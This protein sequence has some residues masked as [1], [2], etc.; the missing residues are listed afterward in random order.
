[1]IASIAHIQSSSVIECHVLQRVELKDSRAVRLRT[2]HQTL[3]RTMT[4]SPSMDAII[5]LIADVH[6]LIRIDHHR[7]G[8]VQLAI[9]GAIDTCASNGYTR[10]RSVCPA[11]DAV[12]VWISDV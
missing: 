7:H 3:T 9:A 12:I 10:T 1:M 2:A 4:D 5:A 11:L 6:D 8:I